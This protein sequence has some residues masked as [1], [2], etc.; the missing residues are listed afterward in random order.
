[1]MS[2][3][4]IMYTERFNVFKQLSYNTSDRL[5]MALVMEEGSNIAVHI[6][7]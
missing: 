3:L 2:C 1:M 6:W 4:N 5:C 7:L